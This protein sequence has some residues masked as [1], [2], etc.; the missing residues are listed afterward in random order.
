MA[1]L[2]S[3]GVAVMLCFPFWVQDRPLL[4]AAYYG[5]MAAAAATALGVLPMFFTARLPQQVQDAMMGFGAGVMLAA[6]AFSL[7]VPGLEVAK[8]QYSATVAVLIIGVG[9]LLGGAGIM[10]MEALLPHEHFFN[11]ADH[12]PLLAVNLRR[13]WLFAFAILLHNLPE[14][15]SIGVAFAGEDHIGAV[16]LAIGISIQ[17]IPEGL[18]VALAL[19]QAGYSRNYSA[20]FGALTG[21]IEPV[22]AVLGALAIGLSSAF[23]PWGLAISAGAMLFV[24]SHEIIPESHRQG[25]EKYATSGLM[26]GFVL[27]MVLDN[28]LG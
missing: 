24:I 6:V 22:G 10:L 4:L 20:G 13:G 18:V 8:T 16:G 17:D 7:I 27:M 21:L 26:L 14:G 9:V 1:A 2:V 25:H 12:N 15:I 19:H 28:A 3:A 23:L 5:G 11:Q